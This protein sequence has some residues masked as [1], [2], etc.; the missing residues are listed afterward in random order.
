VPLPGD[1]YVQNQLSKR[2]VQLCQGVK[3]QQLQYD[4]RFGLGTQS[5]TWCQKDG[6]P[7]IVENNEFLSVLIAK[8]N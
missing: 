3:A 7:S 5:V 1:A 6:W 4:E 8:S 2:G